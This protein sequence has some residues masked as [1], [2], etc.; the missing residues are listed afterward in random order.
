MTKRVMCA[1][2]RRGTTG[3]GRAMVTGVAR[4]GARTVAGVSDSRIRVVKWPGSP[5]L[6][7]MH[8]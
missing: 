4:G 3:K 1:I 5:V 8:S 7:V 6:P 2:L